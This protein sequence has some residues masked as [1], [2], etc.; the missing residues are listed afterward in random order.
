MQRKLNRTALCLLILVGFISNIHSEDTISPKYKRIVS[1]GGNVTETIYALGAGDSVIAADLSSVYPPEI[2]KL[3]RLGYHRAVSSEGIISLEPDLVFITNEAG[4]PEAI[5]QLKS[6]GV[7]VVEVSGDRTFVGC[8]Q[9]IVEIGKVL[10]LENKAEE[11]CKKI[12]Q[13]ME[14]YKKR[15]S[16]IPKKKTA[17]FIFSQSPHTLTIAGENTAG[18]EMLKLAGIENAVPNV[19]GYK[20]FNSEA[21]AGTNP[22]SIVVCAHGEAQILVDNIKE[23]QALKES[24]AVKNGRVI[25]FDTSLLMNFGPRVGEA[26]WELGSEIYPELKNMKEE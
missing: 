7:K 3:E 5:D 4:P 18:D 12:D 13:S 19:Q 15:I 6:A 25:V 23:H 2:F 16:S 17:L 24:A 14:S 1:L 11:L 9:R 8:Q 20:A 10:G 26:A 22:D 21:A